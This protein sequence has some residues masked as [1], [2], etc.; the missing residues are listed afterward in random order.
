MTTAVTA[1]TL[2]STDEIPLIAFK[3]LV[4]RG[5]ALKA[6]VSRYTEDKNFLKK[7]AAV[8]TRTTEILT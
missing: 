2:D 5:K 7:D 6:Q 4:G 3:D 1:E 8:L